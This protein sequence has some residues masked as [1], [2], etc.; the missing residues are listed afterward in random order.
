MEWERSGEEMSGGRDSH[1][2]RLL[3]RA[4]Y[5]RGQLKLNADRK[6]W[7]LQNDPTLGARELGYLQTTNQH[8]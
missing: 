8:R 5:P 4:S 6:P 7:E 2:N 3:Y 1:Q